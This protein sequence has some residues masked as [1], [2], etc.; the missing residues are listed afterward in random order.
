MRIEV[1]INGKNLTFTEAVWHDGQLLG[2]NDN[3]V[4]QIATGKEGIAIRVI[5]KFDFPDS[6]L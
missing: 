2:Y 4:I 3:D 5:S 6:K 1:E